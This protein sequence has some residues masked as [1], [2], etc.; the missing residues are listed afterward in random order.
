MSRMD[1]IGKDER[2]APDE[3]PVIKLDDEAYNAFLAILDT[4]AELNERLRE[5]LKRRPFW[6]N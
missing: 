3:R 4:P 1:L 2:L 5:R 6:E